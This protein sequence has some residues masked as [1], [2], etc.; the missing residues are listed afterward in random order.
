LVDCLVLF[1]A[2]DRTHTVTSKTIPRNVRSCYHAMRDPYTMSRAW[3]GNC[4]RAKSSR[5]TTYSEKWFVCT[6]GGVGG[7][8]WAWGGP[9]NA[10]EETHGWADWVL[11][12]PFLQTFNEGLRGDSGKTNITPA[13]DIHGAQQSWLWSQTALQ[14]AIASC[15]TRL[16]D[17]NPGP[18]PPRDLPPK[19]LHPSQASIPHV[20]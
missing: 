8:P 17:P 20:Y 16:A 1:D 2:V 14:Q 4:G 19:N 13:L 10:I 11:T 18:W 5:H 6:H 9:T 7:V 15:K 3:F 12:R